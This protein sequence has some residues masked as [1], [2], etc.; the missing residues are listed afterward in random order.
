MIG[1]LLRWLRTP[2]RVRWSW[3]RTVLRAPERRSGAA[4]LLAVRFTTHLADELEIRNDGPGDASEI[5]IA[6]IER[7]PD[8]REARRGGGLPS[9]GAGSRYVVSLR[10]GDDRELLPES[11]QAASARGPGRWLW[12]QWSSPN[13]DVGQ[14]SAFDAWDAPPGQPLTPQVRA[15]DGQR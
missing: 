14:S 12:L 9:L 7:D 8:G 4:K 2:L 1:R 10:A 11:A 3:P 15:P 5:R 6:L 13:G